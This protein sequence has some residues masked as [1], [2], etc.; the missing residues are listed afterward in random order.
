MGD[1]LSNTAVRTAMEEGPDVG[2]QER[3]ERLRKQLERVK[4][5]ITEEEEFE[6][7][8]QLVHSAFT[9]LKKELGKTLT[10]EEYQAIDGAY[11]FLHSGS[12]DLVRHVPSAADKGESKRL[13]KVLDAGDA[14]QELEALTNEVK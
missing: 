5:Q 14:L 12:V 3:I 1:R 6:R 11:I 8:W 7:R 10:R 13:E 4:G 9:K 2:R